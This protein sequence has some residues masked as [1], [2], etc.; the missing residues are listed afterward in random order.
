MKTR[1]LGILAIVLLLIIIAL[2][3]MLYAIPTPSAAPATTATTS[4]TTSSTSTTSGSSAP[5][6]TQVSVSSPQS[7]ATVAQTFTVSGQAPGGWFF[8]A[9]FPIQVR[10]PNDNVIGRATGQA[11]GDWQT[12]SLVSFTATIQIDASY[13]GPATLILLKDN[14]SG[15]P[16]NDDS[17][18]V[19]IVIQ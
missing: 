14:P 4:S 2:I 6:S 18:T 12:T 5:L 9:Q 17:V 13:H 16:Q 15:L 11:Q 1:L 19:A 8:E 3:W 10:D 7:G